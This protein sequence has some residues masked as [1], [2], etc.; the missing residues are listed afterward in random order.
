MADLTHEESILYAEIL[1]KKK[2]ITAAVRYGEYHFSNVHTDDIGQV[3]IHATA[4]QASRRRFQGFPVHL[5]VR[6]FRTDRRRFEVIG[7]DGDWWV[8]AV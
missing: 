1:R 6:Y 8:R 4:I 5:M 2:A 7:D 3:W